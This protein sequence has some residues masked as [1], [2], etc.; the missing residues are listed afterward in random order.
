MLE[1]E[2]ATANLPLFWTERAQQ[3]AERLETWARE[4]TPVAACS[5]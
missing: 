2:S 4:A 3:M 5:G 1:T